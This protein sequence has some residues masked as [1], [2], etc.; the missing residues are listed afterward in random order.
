MLELFP[1]NVESQQISSTVTT[2]KFPTTQ[3]GQQDGSTR[4]EHHPHFLS[5]PFAFVLSPQTYP[6]TILALFAI[7]YSRDFLSPSWHSSLNDDA[8]AGTQIHHDCITPCLTLPAAVGSGHPTPHLVPLS[9]PETGPPETTQNT[10]AVTIGHPYGNVE[11]M[12]SE[13]PPRRLLPF[14]HGRRKEWV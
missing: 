2:V 3:Y 5:L 1:H 7:E 4:D 9:A 8:S 12:L 14:L 6:R 11:P 10:M 13:T